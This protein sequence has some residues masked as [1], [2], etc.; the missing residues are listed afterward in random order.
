MIAH[1]QRQRNASAS[2]LAWSNWGLW[3]CLLLTL[4]EGERVPYHKTLTHFTSHCESHRCNHTYQLGKQRRA[5][6]NLKTGSFTLSRVD[7]A[8]RKRHASTAVSH[9]LCTGT[10]GRRGTM[11]VG[12]HQVIS[13]GR[14]TQS[15]TATIKNMVV[16]EVV[17]WIGC[18]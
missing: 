17:N 3:R 12:K 15:Q 10:E 1:Q 11:S 2:P 5:G 13:D 8:Q 6:R 16:V 14:L 7:V 9:R 4:E 18:E